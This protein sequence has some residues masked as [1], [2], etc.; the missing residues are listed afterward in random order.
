MH[1]KSHRSQWSLEAGQD[2]HHLSDFSIR[3]TFQTPPF[4]ELTTDHRE[5]AR[6][7]IRKDKDTTKSIDLSIPDKLDN[8]IDEG[9]DT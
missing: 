9:R 7:N 1:R 4:K 2:G 3:S 6:E 5:D 8:N